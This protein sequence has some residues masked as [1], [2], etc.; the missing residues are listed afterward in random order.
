MV[1]KKYTNEDIAF[2]VERTIS[3]FDLSLN[4]KKNYI[5]I[6]AFSNLAICLKNNLI[7]K[8]YN[9]FLKKE[10]KI[11]DII[12]ND[13]LNCIEILSKITPLKS[14][15]LKMNVQSNKNKKKNVN[16]ISIKN[17][18]TRPLNL[19]DEINSSI[20]NLSNSEKRSKKTNTNVSNESCNILDSS[21]SMSQV[22]H[23]DIK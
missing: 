16:I 23:Y 6:S 21:A 7:A 3:S 14:N 20:E 11:C 10:Q 9:N 2:Y 5:C 17:I 4:N 1:K 8:V 15:S 19:N 22:S 13:M 12:K 18:N